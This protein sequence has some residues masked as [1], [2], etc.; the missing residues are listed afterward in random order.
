MILAFTSVQGFATNVQTEMIG[1][2]SKQIQAPDQITTLTI[3][4]PI[5]ASDLYF[6][7]T[8]MTKLT[9]LNLEKATIE[10]YKDASLNGSTHYP[11]NAIPPGA[12]AGSKLETIVLPAANKTTI[13]NGAFMNSALKALPL[14]IDSIGHAA[15]AGC[16]NI[17]NLV[18]SDVKL[19]TD[20]FADCANL[21]TVEFTDITAVPARTFR[22]CT[23]LS[24][25]IGGGNITVVGAQAFEGDIALTTF[26]FGA[27][28]IE[29]GQRAFA[30]TGL[31]S[32]DLTN[33]PKIK[34]TGSQL[35]A[36]SQIEH[37][38]LN[39]NTSD[40]PEG[41]LFGNSK[42]TEITLPENLITIGSHAFTGTNLKN[43][44]LPSNLEEIGDYALYGQSDIQNIELPST[45][46]YIG[47]RAMGNMTGLKKIDATA[48]SSV[49]ELGQDVWEGVDQPNVQLFVTYDYYNDFANA[50]QWKEFSIDNT[51]D[52]IDNVITM[53]GESGVKGRFVGYELQIESASDIIRRVNLYDLSGRALLTLDPQDT[54]AYIDTTDIPGSIFIINVVLDNNITASL[55]LARH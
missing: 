27:N 26:D 6:I 22:G 17:V 46:L 31:Q 16:E 55:K 34:T 43:L 51:T 14:N 7:G 35:F 30:G 24:T 18:L 53:L 8:Q 1:T 10:A 37:I 20:A 42:L 54:A 40:L 12:F 5:D 52:A 11:A 3:T 41:A 2:L 4:G 44:S 48:L 39:A 45:V 32:V 9:S 50:P 33:S 21:K 23:S 15:F 25:I 29:I 13:D 38:N 19:G 47:E 28:L 36:D 49:P